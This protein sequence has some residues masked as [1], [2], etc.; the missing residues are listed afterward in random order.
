[1]GR[2][3]T[4]PRVL[5]RKFRRSKNWSR[6]WESSRRRNEY[7]SLCIGGVDLRSRPR[8][9]YAAG[10]GLSQQADP[11]HPALRSRR[12]HRH[13]RATPRA[14]AERKSRTIG[15]AREPSGRG[16]HGR[17]RCVVARSA[18]DGYAMLLTDPGLVSNPTLQADVP[19]DLFKGLQGVSIVGS[20][21]VIVAS[22]KL[23]VNTLPELIAYAKDNP[24]KLNFASAGIGTAPH[25]A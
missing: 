19:Y 2:P 24:G 17:R 20:P 5:R 1:G 4:S 14:A 22:L 23:P 13:R 12:H 25:L 6:D 21:A 10:A 15:R 16:R 7:V 3:K 9:A 8:A 18:P 11:L